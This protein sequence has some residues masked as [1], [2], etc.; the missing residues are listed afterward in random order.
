MSCA[1]CHTG[2][3]TYNGQKYLIDGGQPLLDFYGFMY[4]LKETMRKILDD[5][6]KDS[7]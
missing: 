1:A 7:F 6:E 4:D 3:L 2:E 5:D